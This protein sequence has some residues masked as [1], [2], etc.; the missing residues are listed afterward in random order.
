MNLKPFKGKFI[1][2][3]PARGN[4][5]R[6][7]DKNTLLLDG[8]P[9]IAYTIESAIKSKMFNEI[10]ISSEDPKILKISRK[11]EVNTDKRPKHL[12]KDQTST[13]D[14]VKNILEKKRDFNL[15]FYCSQLARSELKNILLLPCPC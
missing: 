15:W 6:L 14:V 1:A 8:K 3:I 11:Y 7:K 5:K 12:S 4:S 2:I 13:F 10:I 9:L